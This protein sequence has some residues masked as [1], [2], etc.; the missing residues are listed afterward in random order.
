MNKTQIDLNLPIVKLIID[1][2]GLIYNHSKLLYLVSG[3][4]P[5]D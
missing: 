3:K 2:V 5:P 4:N 1:A